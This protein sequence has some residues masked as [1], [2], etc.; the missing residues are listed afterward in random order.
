MHIWIANFKSLGR[1]STI[2]VKDYYFEHGIAG[3]GWRLDDENLSKDEYYKEA[4]NTWIGD[5]SKIIKACENYHRIERGDLILATNGV[6][7][8]LGLVEDDKPFYAKTNDYSKAKDYSVGWC[9][10]IKWCCIGRQDDTPALIVGKL[11]AR[12]QKTI[13][14][15]NEN[16]TNRSLY[17]YC[18]LVYNELSKTQTFTLDPPKKLDENNF[19]NCL[20]AQELEDLVGLFLQE[21]YGYLFYPSSCKTAT[22]SFEYILINK[23]TNET[24]YAQVKQNARI[25]V[26]EYSKKDYEKSLIYLFSDNGYNNL[27]QSENIKIIDKSELFAYFKK[28]I[29]IFQSRMKYEM[30]IYEL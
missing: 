25:N 20:S 11:S 29:S 22:K 3:M 14:I 4:F 10:K 15:R 1:N 7:Y 5:D 27:N 23:E 18:K 16:E 24:V 9:R 6:L 21:T 26:A 19:A 8:Y 12:Q 17:K 28:Y 13:D 30:K 2:E